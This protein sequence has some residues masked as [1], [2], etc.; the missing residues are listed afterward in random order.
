LCFVV[1]H[2]QRSGLAM[3][4]QGLCGGM[5][6]RE[7]G[8]QKEHEVIGAYAALYAV[9][10]AGTFFLAIPVLLLRYLFWDAPRLERKRMLREERATMNAANND[11]IKGV[12]K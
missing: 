10:A 2:Y 9:V 11:T 4:R 3:H 1:V 7:Q 8:A 12:K 5:A 6:R